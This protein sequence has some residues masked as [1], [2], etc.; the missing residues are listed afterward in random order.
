LKNYFILLLAD[1]TRKIAK[2]NP[3]ASEIKSKE[4]TGVKE[5]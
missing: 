3:I 1:T 2:I 4:K 5:F